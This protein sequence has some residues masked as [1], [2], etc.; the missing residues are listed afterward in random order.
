[1]KQVWEI[2]RD[3]HAHSGHRLALLVVLLIITGLSDG[4]SMALL[5]PLLEIV[6]MNGRAPADQGTVSTTVHRFTAW[7][8]VTPT[9]TSISLLLVGSFLLQAVL[10]ISQ[11]WFLFDIQKK[12]VASWQQRLVGDFLAAD[13]S[14][15]AAQKHGQ[16]VN[17]V[18]VE[19]LRLGAALFGILQLIVAGVVLCIYL[20]VAIIVSWKVTLFLAA[21]SF[22]LL[23]LGRPIRRATRRY[24]GE[25][26]Q[27]NADVATTLNEILSGVKLIKASASEAKANRSMA[28]HI[29]RLRRNV[30]WSAFLP[31]TTRSFFEFF[32]IIMILSAVLY[33]LKVQHIGA[34]ELLVIVALIGRLLPRLAQ[35]QQ[36]NSMV[37]LSA[38]VHPLLRGIHDGFAAHREI[39]RAQPATPRRLELALPVVISGRDLVMRYGDSVVLDGVSFMVPG[40]KVVGFVGRSGAGKSTLI[41]VIIG[42]VQPSEGE[43]AVSG[44]PLRDVDLTA[45]RERIGYVS[46]DTFLFHDTIANNIRWSTPGAS[47]AEIE[48]SARQ[49]GLAPF[50]ASLPQRYDTIVGD[51]GVKLSGGQRQRISLARALIRAPALLV[52]DEPTSALDSI[53]EQE[54]MNVISTLRGKI[55]VI[56][57]AHRLS[58]VRD[59]DLIYVMDE[60]RIVEQG[61]WSALSERKAA[62]HRLLQSQSLG[63]PIG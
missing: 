22:V 14:Y 15:F 13:W 28:E 41:D 21:G 48:A 27:I 29:E 42:L 51:R 61:S 59:A 34:A 1:M 45:W 19:C 25:L 52:L 44:V 32:A 20:V 53:S 49:A 60:G 18:L 35:I 54:I 30:T 9:L 63:E 58:T 6:G 47:T 26:A 46:Q 57:V 24:G 37:I 38:P 3:A 12:Y 55:T 7:L 8:G 5:Y 40:G 17:F 23:V 50:I 33:G 4:V 11:N 62:F 10:V 39:K 2:L 16:L 56:I 36:F 31:S 43:L